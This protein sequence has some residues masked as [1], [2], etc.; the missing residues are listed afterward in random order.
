MPSSM[1]KHGGSDKHR[2]PDSI[3]LLSLVTWALI[4]L[5]RRLAAS[6]E[7]WGNRDSYVTQ[8]AAHS[9]EDGRCRPR[10]LPALIALNYSIASDADEGTEHFSSVL[11][12]GTQLL[13]RCHVHA[14]PPFTFKGRPHS[15]LLLEVG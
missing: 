7:R 10:P 5:I 14:W 8:T 15:S 11:L 6:C 9:V 4:L 12:L 3:H 2:P 13:R 1:L